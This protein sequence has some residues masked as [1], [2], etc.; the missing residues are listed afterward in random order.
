[1]ITKEDLE[2][3]ATAQL[4]VAV[5]VI[6]IVSFDRTEGEII[7]EIEIEGTDHTDSSNTDRLLLPITLSI[8]I[9]KNN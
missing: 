2:I 1:M 6:D 3:W 5:Q 4:G 7:C 8:S 9:A